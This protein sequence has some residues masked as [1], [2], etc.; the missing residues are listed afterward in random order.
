MKISKD[1]CYRAKVVSKDF[2]EA[3]TGTIQL[4]IGFEVT[5]EG[6]QKGN[7]ITGFFPCTENSMS[8]TVEKMRALGWKG[9]DLD[10]LSTLGTEEADI[11]V[12]SE[13]YNGESRLKVAFV[14]KPG[15]VIVPPLDS[16]RRKAFAARMRSIVVGTDP[17]QAAAKAAPP[18][19]KTPTVSDEDL[20][21]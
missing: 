3:K 6:D 12:K 9:V 8:Y 7:T 18:E 21:F 19:A 11:V 1:G 20:P 17:S 14:N 5:Q 13:S 4:V 10:D 2:N 15:A 16:D